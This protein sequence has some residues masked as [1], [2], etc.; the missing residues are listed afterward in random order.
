MKLVALGALFAVEAPMPRRRRGRVSA[1]PP[2]P[3]PASTT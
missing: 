2:S 1:S 3:P